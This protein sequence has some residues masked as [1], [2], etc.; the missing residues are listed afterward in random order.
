MTKRAFAH[1]VG[2]AK[3]C[4]FYKKSLVW[5][6]YPDKL[7]LKIT[8]YCY[9]N[10]IGSWENYFASKKLAKNLIVNKLCNNNYRNLKVEQSINFCCRSVKLTQFKKLVF[11][12]LFIKVTV[13]I[14]VISNLLETFEDTY[15]MIESHWNA[16]HASRLALNLPTRFKI[17]KKLI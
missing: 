9:K 13:G 3:L 4:S 7:R 17:A 2:L 8:K 1:F 6:F 10:S 11:L 14:F 16:S 15:I 5:K 12:Q